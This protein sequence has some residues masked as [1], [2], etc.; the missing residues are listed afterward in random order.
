MK[1]A[2]SNLG[3]GVLDLEH[4][5]QAL[6]MVAVLPSPEFISLSKMLSKKNKRN[7]KRTSVIFFVVVD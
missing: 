5:R 7:A 4:T 2:F 6:S 3:S 1:P